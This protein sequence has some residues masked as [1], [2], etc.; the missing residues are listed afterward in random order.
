MRIRLRVGLRAALLIIAGLGSWLGLWANRARDQARALRWI[1][2]HGGQVAFDDAGDKGGS[3]APAWLRH[4]VGDD[5]FR[6]VEE[7]WFADASPPPMPPEGLRLLARLP[8]LRRLQVS[9]G[10]DAR[11]LAEIG[12]MRGLE[13]LEVGGPGVTD[14]GLVHL[15]GL[16]RLEVLSLT[17]T[18][19]NDAGL[20]HLR[21]LKRLRELNLSGTAK[22]KGPGLAL[23]AGL[24]QLRYLDL[25]ET[26]VGDEALRHL[27]ELPAVRALTLGGQVTDAGIREVA[28]VDGLEELH[29]YNAP[30]T[31]AGI[32]RVLSRTRLARLSLHY[33]HVSP[34]RMARI[35]RDHP[36]IDFQASW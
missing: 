35:E 13:D 28:R 25:N 22:V 12:R 1:E 9:G 34:E 36:T 32:D 15:A 26:G 27:P 31:D 7:V 23:L 16:G 11:H 19:V 3:R 17:G 30:V 21:G 29:L 18:D 5:F 20:A 4:R 14:A 8:G 6:R 24:P 33:T 2:R 10:V